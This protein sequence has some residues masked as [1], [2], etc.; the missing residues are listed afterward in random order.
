MNAEMHAELYLKIETKIIKIK[1]M[2]TKFM[3]GAESTEMQNAVKPKESLAYLMYGKDKSLDKYFDRIGEIK[4]STQDKVHTTVRDW[5]EAN[6]DKPAVS[7]KGMEGDL[8]IGRLFTT[9]HNELYKSLALIKKEIEKAEDEF[10]KITTE[11][12]NK[13]K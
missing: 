5:M 7:G 10:A 4:I 2:K 8:T 13:L 1:D 12:Q 9:I 11:A 3:D 6:R